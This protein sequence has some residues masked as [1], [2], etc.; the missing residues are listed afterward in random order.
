MSFP[1]AP[2]SVTLNDLERRN[3]PNVC[4]ITLNLVA[5][6]TDYVKVVEDTPIRSAAVLHMLLDSWGD[7]VPLTPPDSNTQPGA[8]PLNTSGSRDR[9]PCPQTSDENDL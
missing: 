6:G 7:F 1:L 8:L 2:K 4:V 9:G 5:F 3:R